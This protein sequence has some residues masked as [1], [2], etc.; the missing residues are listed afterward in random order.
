MIRTA[1]YQFLKDYLNQQ[2]VIQLLLPHYDFYEVAAAR[3]R[4]VE[5]YGPEALRKLNGF[6][7]FYRLSH[8]ENE[9]GYAE[10]EIP[11][12]LWLKR[13]TLFGE[14][15]D[16]LNAFGHYRG[17]GQRVWR[18]KSEK[19]GWMKREEEQIDDQI[20]TELEARAGEM[21][22]AAEVVATL[23]QGDLRDAHPDEVQAWMSKAAPS[24]VQ[25]AWLHKYLH[26]LYP[27]LISP[28]ATPAQ[29]RAILAFFGIE[30]REG[31]LYALD[32][33]L[34]AIWRNF[35]DHERRREVTF[36]LFNR[37]LKGA[38]RFER[39]EPGGG[40]GNRW[41]RLH[42]LP[43][44]R[45]AT[46]S[47]ELD[48]LTQ[49]VFEMLAR[50]K[51]VILYGPPGTGKSYHASRVALS[52]IAQRNYYRPP[53]Q[54][55]QATRAEIYGSHGGVPQI[56]TCTFHPMYAYEDFIEGYR[57]Q[58]AGFT[59]RA[60]IFKAMA[61]TAR[62]HPDRSY[63]LIID[64]INRG[65]IPKIFG[66]L[67][68]LIEASKRDTLSVR[69]PLSQEIFTVPSN[70]VILGTMNTADRSISLL[71]SALRRRFA[72]KE[73]LPQPRLLKGGQIGALPLSTWLC[74]LN[75]RIIEVLGR[76]GRNL[77]IGHAY[78][79]P[80]ERPLTELREIAAVIRDDI[81]PLLQEYCYEDPQQLSE[82]L[83]GEA[84]IYDARRMDLRD[85]LFELGQKQALT[86]AL[87]AVVS[88]DLKRRCEAP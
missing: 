66:E 51:Q 31:D 1:L 27:E 12:D 82:I 55:T 32:M 40:K 61:T 33:K 71:D 39:F 14:I 8:D 88:D 85:E 67:I 29:A 25:S 11:M 30:Q 50:K 87:C 21:Y 74:A 53:E 17:K 86:E 6:D 38:S 48:P 41:Q 59:L 5:L 24:W 2:N 37:I 54:L 60:G 43:R 4:F 19:R 78:F 49:Q 84:G 56:A 65:N 57:P 64:E 10:P 34:H 81:W 16:N 68:T 9:E 76:D 75:R 46:V 42:A 58:G 73:L 3:A 26:L 80:Q 83:G 15:P 63:A 36:E 44:A 35:F 79:M 70:L 13:D 28:F 52:W 7:L 77:Q 69:L 18:F 22:S 47:S 72:F 62:R 45:R 23:L 20:L